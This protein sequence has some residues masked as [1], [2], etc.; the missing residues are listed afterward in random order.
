MGCPVGIYVLLSPLPTTTRQQ[1]RS[2][3][4][5]DR[6]DL[7]PTTTNKGS[8]SGAVR[9]IHVPQQ[10]QP[11]IGV[12]LGPP[13]GIAPSRVMLRV[14]QLL[15]GRRRVDNGKEWTNKTS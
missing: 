5:S 14:C 10:Q 3:A 11:S 4:T 15:R 8:L 13:R 2:V 7:P 6:H 1:P 12:L 9:R